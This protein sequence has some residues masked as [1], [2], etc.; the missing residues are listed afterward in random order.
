MII[1]IEKIISYDVSLEVKHEILT[2][3]GLATRDE[4]LFKA[5]EKARN[6]LPDNPAEIQI[7][8]EALLQGKTVS[9]IDDRDNREEEFIDISRG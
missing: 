5:C 9:Y 2:A 1:A 7:T 8:K 6:N 3:I 4:N